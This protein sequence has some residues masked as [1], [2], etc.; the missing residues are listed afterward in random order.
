MPALPRCTFL[1][2]DPDTGD[3]MRCARWQGH[4]PADEHRSYRDVHYSMC[5]VL[6]NRAG[7]DNIH[8]L[9]G[10]Q[11]IVLS[12]IARTAYIRLVLDNPR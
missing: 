8:T 6:A 11:Q 10:T 1:G 3:I 5:Q 7:A 9:N 12:A 4:Q 2:E